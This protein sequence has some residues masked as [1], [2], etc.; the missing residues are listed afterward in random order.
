MPYAR[1]LQRFTRRGFY[2]EPPREWVRRLR[3]ISP[4]LPNLDHL[5]F[6]RFDGEED[7]NGSWPCKEARERG[8]LA[9]YAAKPIAM[10]EKERAK[11]FDRHWSELAEEFQAGR[12]ACVSDYQHF[13]WHSRGLYVRPFLILQGEWGG[14]PAKYT[15]KERAF[16]KASHCEHEP[17]DIGLF[18]PI[19]FDERVVRQITLRDRLLQVSNSY[20]AL[21]ELDTS[22]GLG[23]EFD[24]AEQ[25]RRETFLDT[26]AVMNQP[27]VEFYKQLYTSSQTSKRSHAAESQLPPAPAGLSDTLAKWKDHFLQTGQWLHGTPAPQRVLHDVRIN[28]N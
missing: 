20:G 25:V 18:P 11:Q 19:P 14:T 28:V 4:E 27:A 2:F 1:A 15:E 8:V 23:R 6:R 16:L 26:L 5:V 24:E 13:M 9:L 12:R 22:E 10:V 21:E 3:E 7:G 17:F